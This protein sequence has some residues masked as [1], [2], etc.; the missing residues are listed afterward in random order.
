MDQILKRS[1]GL[2]WG[3]VFAGGKGARLTEENYEDRITG[4]HEW[5][6]MHFAL[7]DHRA[8]RFLETFDAVPAPVRTLLLSNET[9]LQIHL[10]PHSAHGIL[11][12]IEKYFEGETMGAGR[13]AFYLDDRSLI[14]VRH[15]PMRVVD[16]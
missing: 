4:P 11:P 7:S 14:T 3:L 12:D 6:W 1:P 10:A 9:R 13:L 15:R 16:E 8:R 2:L 5:A